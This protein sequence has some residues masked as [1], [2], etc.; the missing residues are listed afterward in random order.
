MGA[1]RDDGDGKRPQRDL[2][3]RRTVVEP[4]VGE[5]IA[6]GSGMLGATLVEGDTIVVGVVVSAPA[7]S[8][9]AGAVVTVGAVVVVAMV[10]VG[11]APS[12]NVTGADS[13]ATSALW[14]MIR[15]SVDH[16]G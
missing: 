9:V 8:G 3:D 10:V 2:G 11:A 1:D 4:A 5:G 7:V 16:F 15:L 6:N 13:S 14:T 12:G